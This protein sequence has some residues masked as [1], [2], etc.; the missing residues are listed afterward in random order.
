MAP[1]N[2]WRYQSFIFLSASLNATLAA[3][4]NTAPIGHRWKHQHRPKLKGCGRNSSFCRLLCYAKLS[5]GRTANLCSALLIWALYGRKTLRWGVLFLFNINFLLNI[6]LRPEGNWTCIRNPSN[7][8]PDTP[9][10]RTF[11]QLMPLSVVSGTMTCHPP[12]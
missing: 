3:T 11:S 4:A 1:W 9:N 2:H 12:F 7:L 8:H 10:L 6:N 5:G